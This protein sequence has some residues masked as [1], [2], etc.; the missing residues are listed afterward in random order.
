MKKY[1]IYVLAFLAL[2]AI[3]VNISAFKPAEKAKITAG[4]Y[5]L[6]EIY[7]IPA[8]K[9]K[10]LHIH[11]GNNKT[12]FIPFKEF[13]SPNHDEN[14]E[15]IISTINKLVEQGYIIDHTA[16]GLANGGMITKIFLKKIS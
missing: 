7:E 10:G 1:T 15:I 12:E 16:A 11:Y 8:Y 14:G 6:V 2:V 3:I 5:I 9:D 4:G 13:V